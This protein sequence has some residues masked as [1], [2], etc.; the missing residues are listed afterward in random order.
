MIDFSP[1][2]LTFTNVDRFYIKKSIYQF[3]VSKFSLFGG[4]LLDIGCGEMPYKE[5]ILTNTHVVNYVGLD[6]YE[7][8]EYKAGVKPDYFWDGV[9]MPFENESFDCAFATEVLE[10]CPD[11][12][13]T[14]NEIHRVLKPNAP[15]IFTVPFLWPTHES[16]NDYYRY[17]PFA[18]EKL[19]KEAGFSRIE[20]EVL[21]G[22]DA[23][24]AQMIGLWIKRRGIS[25]PKQRILYT[26]LKY[27]ILVLYRIDHKR[28]ALSDQNMFTGL[29]VTAWK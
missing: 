21:G 15:F 17:T 11:P 22:W 6:I 19:L 25:K 7:A 24:L 3:L 5:V 23:S 1:K 13:I 20:V 14:L 16:P 2:K 12:K 8:I 29:G 28:N 9:T 10:H 27:F 18:M 26:F 4:R